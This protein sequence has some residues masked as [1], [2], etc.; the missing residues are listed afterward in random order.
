MHKN[1]PSFAPESGAISGGHRQ[2]LHVTRIIGDGPLACAGEGVNYRA[3][4]LMLP[5]LFSCVI[6]LHG[7]LGRASPC[8][9]ARGL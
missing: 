5:K 1:T 2:G 6:R 7:N 4:A 3:G 8:V 9:D